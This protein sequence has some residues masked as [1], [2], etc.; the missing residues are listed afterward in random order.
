MNTQ[1]TNEKTQSWHSSSGHSVIE[2]LVVV[3]IATVLGAVT[4]PQIIS[5]RRLMRSAALP[6]EVVTQLRFAKQQAMSQRQAFTFQY[7]D[8]TKKIKIIDHNNNGN[9]TASCNVAGTAILADSL[10]PNTACSTTVLTVPLGGG[11]V[12]AADISIGVPPGLSGV[13]TLDDTTT[14]TSLTAFKLNIT[15]QP[16]G[17]VIDV[18]NNPVNRTLFLYNNRVPTQ[19]AVAI[20]VLGAAGRVKVWRY[21]SSVN[22]YAE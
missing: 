20:S 8:S 15:F 6:R 21:S 16:D 14:P 9:P 11:P 17:S 22:K 7:D 12:P 13:S 3:A 10:Y 5:A 2:T 18:N 4:L 19:T 1:A